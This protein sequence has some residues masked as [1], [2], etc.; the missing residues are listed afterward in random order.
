MYTCVDKIYVVVPSRAF[1]PI[2]QKGRNNGRNWNYRGNKAREEVAP[3]NMVAYQ[4][5]NRDGC[6]QRIFVSEVEFDRKLSQITRAKEDVKVIVFPETTKRVLD[7]AF[8]NTQLMSVVLNEGL[9]KL[10]R[11]SFMNS[12]IESV[13]IPANTLAI[14]A[15]AFC[16]CWRL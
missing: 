9:Q 4:P 11:R 1:G 2:M 8:Q 5:H 13:T 15:E 6:E 3:R 16:D 12:S 14:G 7:G 10:G